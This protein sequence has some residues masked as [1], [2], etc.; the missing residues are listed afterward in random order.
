MEIFKNIIEE[1]VKNK[2]I[3]EKHGNI[4]VA[5][6]QRFSE[7]GDSLTTTKEIAQT[8][9][10]SE[11]A[12]FKYYATKDAL[13]LALIDIIL[14]EIMVPLISTG[15]EDLANQKYD[16]LEDFFRALFHN[17]IQLLEYGKPIMRILLLEMPIRPDVRE[18]V[19]AKIPEIPL[20]LMVNSMKAQGFFQD[21][22]TEQ[23]IN[24]LLTGFIGFLL[25][26]VILLPE[27]F[28]NNQEQELE[29]WI[30]FMAK[31]FSAFSGGE[32]K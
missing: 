1:K 20:S 7:K 6:F 31:G 2:I 10:V 8:A 5:A 22:T 24:L 4:L 32:A 26:R 18:R 16:H 23:V 21:L 3:T 19:H 29:H 9:G 30:Q 13:I 28:Q 27:R 17:R 12:I 14:E 25:P 11:A 15:F